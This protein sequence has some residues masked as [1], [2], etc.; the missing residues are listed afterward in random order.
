MA[1]IT[2]TIPVVAGQDTITASFEV[3]NGSNRHFLA[4][5]LAADN[6][7]LS[8]GDASSDLN[9]SPTNIDIVMGVDVSGEWTFTCTAQGGV[10]ETDFIV[11]AQTGNSLSLVETTIGGSP[12]NGSGKASGNDIQFTVIGF[13]C[14]TP[15]DLT[16]AG[17]LYSDG[18][19]IGTFATTGGSSGTWIAVR[20]H[21]TPPPPP[22]LGTISG[23]VTD[24]VTG[25]ALDGVSVSLVNQGSTIGTVTTALDG[26]YTLSAAAGSGYSLEFSKS[27][28][29]SQTVSDISI[30]ANAVTTVNV[31]LTTVLSAG[32]ARIVLTW[33][34]SKG[35]LDLDS[36]LKGPRA[37]GDTISGPFHTWFADMTYI[38]NG[39]EYVA[40]DIDWISPADGPVPQETTTIYQQVSGVYTFYVHDYTNGG[41]TGSLALSNSSAQV[42]VYLGNTLAATYNVPASQTGTV[43]TVFQLNGSTLTPINTMSSNETVLLSVSRGYL[44]RK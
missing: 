41:S 27:G 42:R 29:I 21:I 31:V 7:V 5:A 15:F 10:P 33:D 20:G 13:A 32:Q 40:L 2:D 25:K 24:A 34:Y 37:P 30:Q 14:G 1:T 3:P 26:A 17:A 22:S 38:F 23:T 4:A 28:Y 19:L 44:K 6:T 8:Q 9:G 35:S 16:A 18:S 43:W 11:F 39:I 12:F 36:H